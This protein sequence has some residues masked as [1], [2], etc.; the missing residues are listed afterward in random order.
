MNQNSGN[1]FEISWKD[2]RTH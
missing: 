2:I 1:D